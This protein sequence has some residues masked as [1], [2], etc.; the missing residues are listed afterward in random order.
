MSLLH[1]HAFTPF[2]ARPMDR[3]GLVKI[4]PGRLGHWSV[5]DVY[6]R[7]ACGKSRVREVEGQWSLEEIL[8]KP[9]K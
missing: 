3:V 8:G 2:K 6:E 7:C 1:R 4:A 5:T 9:S